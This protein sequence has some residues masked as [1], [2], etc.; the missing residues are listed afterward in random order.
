VFETGWQISVIPA[1]GGTE[2]PLRTL[3]FA[4]DPTWSPAGD[5]ILYAASMNGADFHLAINALDTDA[6]RDLFNAVT[7]S[8]D[9]S[10]SWR[11][12]P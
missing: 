2:R 9:P 6:S 8:G 5:E 7:T 3:P 1:E 11:T 10:P 4:L 12:V